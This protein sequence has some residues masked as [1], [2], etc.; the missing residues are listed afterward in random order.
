MASILPP[1]VIAFLA[2][3]QTGNTSEL[4]HSVAEDVLYLY[5]TDEAAARADGIEAL[6]EIINAIHDVLTGLKL[7]VTEQHVDGDLVRVAGLLDATS[8]K[9]IPGGFQFGQRVHLSIRFGIK[10]ENDKIVKLFESS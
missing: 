10:V 5:V 4:Q 8:Q 1:A 6:G 9:T 7:T 2:A 3:Y